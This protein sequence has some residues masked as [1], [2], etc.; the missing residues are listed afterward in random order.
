[1][2]GF[3]FRYVF[4]S[5]CA[6]PLQANCFAMPTYSP[7]LLL[8]GLALATLC[9]F[10]RSCFRIVELSQG[11]SGPLANDEVTFMVS[12]NYPPRKNSC[13]YIYAHGAG[14]RSLKAR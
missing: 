9:T 4:V 1:M 12:G 3:S 10:A 6:L 7:P 13:M 11:F 2:E 5:S 8:A 14:I